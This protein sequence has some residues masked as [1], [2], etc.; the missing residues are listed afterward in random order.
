MPTQL[1]EIPALHFAYPHCCSWQRR[2]TCS[3]GI[4][5]PQSF[6]DISTSECCIPS[7]G[8]K[9]VPACKS[10]LISFSRSIIWL[11]SKL[12]AQLL[13]LLQDKA[14]Q[15]DKGYLPAFSL[16]LSF[17]GRSE[18]KVNLFYVTFVWFLSVTVGLASHIFIQK[19]FFSPPCD[20]TS[21]CLV[22]HVHA[23]GLLPL[24]FVCLRLTNTDLPWNLLS[25]KGNKKTKSCTKSTIS[26]TISTAKVLGAS[27]FP[28]KHLAD[29]WVSAL[30]WADG[31]TVLHWRNLHVKGSYIWT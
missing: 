17:A 10:V 27:L 31:F 8:F 24:V 5:Q 6:P 30:T 29:G 21:P 26:R 20:K 23:E 4:P 11:A 9:V 15:L 2:T 19:K 16:C 12:G 7:P 28:W 25:P 22:S 13:Y 1:Q 14:G 3:I 18:M